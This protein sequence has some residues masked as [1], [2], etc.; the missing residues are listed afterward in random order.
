MKK[1]KHQILF[2]VSPLHKAYRHIVTTM[3]RRI[4]KL[5][6]TAEEGHLLAYLALYQPKTVGELIRVFGFRNS[7]LT[8]ILNRM[9]QRKLIKRQINSADRRSYLIKVTSKGLKVGLAARKEALLFDKQVLGHVSA[10]DLK[11]FNNILKAVEK[12]TNKTIDI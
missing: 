11:G 7:T 12:E 2:I 4:E 1:Q 6:L 3:E 10:N 8:G 5:D 9:E